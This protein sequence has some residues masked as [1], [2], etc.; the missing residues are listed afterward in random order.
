MWTASHRLAVSVREMGRSE[1]KRGN[2]YCLLTKFYNV[3][4][5]KV[6]TTY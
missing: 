6:K 2:Q 1:R 3:M 4:Y 5:T